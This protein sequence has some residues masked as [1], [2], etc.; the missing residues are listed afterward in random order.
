MFGSVAEALM[1]RAAA[2]LVVYRPRE[3]LAARTDA[4]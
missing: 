4:R 2:A 1:R 3:A